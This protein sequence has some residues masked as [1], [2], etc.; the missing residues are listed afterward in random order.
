V[1]DP[2]YMALYSCVYNY[3]TSCTRPSSAGKRVYLAGEELYLHLE[4]YIAAHVAAMPPVNQPRPLYS[5]KAR[6]EPL[7]VFFLA[8][9]RSLGR[10]RHASRSLRR[11]VRRLQQKGEIT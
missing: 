3:C 7:H 2:Y 6:P 4:T 8:F 11:S 10:G 9:R 5:Q 1:S